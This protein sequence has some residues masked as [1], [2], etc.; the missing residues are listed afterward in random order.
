[1]ISLYVKVCEVWN[2]AAQTKAIA[3]DGDS[4]AIGVEYRAGMGNCDRFW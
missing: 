2:A 1:M 3:G 4:L